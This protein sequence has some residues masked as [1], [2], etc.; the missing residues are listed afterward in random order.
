MKTHSQPRTLAKVLGASSAHG[1]TNPA[2]DR[3]LLAAWGLCEQ[4]KESPDNAT[5]SSSKGEENRRELIL[6]D[7][8]RWRKGKGWSRLPWPG[9]ATLPQYT[10]YRDRSVKIREVGG[11]EE[12]VTA[13]TL[14]SGVNKDKVQGSPSPS[15]GH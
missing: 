11:G 8:C 15:S 14:R 4:Q 6:A 12:L 13:V 7:T 3:A 5:S 10:K 1:A 9:S 2:N